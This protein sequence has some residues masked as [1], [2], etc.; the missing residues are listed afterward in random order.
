MTDVEVRS[1]PESQVS[2]TRESQLWNWFYQG[3][4]HYRPSLHIQR[5][6]NLVMTGVPD[7]EGF[8]LGTQFW[9][10]LKS[11]NDSE[12]FDVEV[13]PEQVMWHRARQLAGGKT[14]FLI[15]EDDKRWVLDR[16][17]D[18]E[19]FRLVLEEL[20]IP[21]AQVERPRLLGRGDDP[22]APRG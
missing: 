16:L 13:S 17:A 15:V 11:I 10:E 7:V 18:H 22:T 1:D 6:E 8:F 4:K 12:C 21:I 9:V 5:V 2:K 3:I 19:R 20:G 14:W